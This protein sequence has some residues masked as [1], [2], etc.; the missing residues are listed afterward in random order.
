MALGNMQGDG[1]S[2]PTCFYCGRQGH[3]KKNCF[4]WQRDN[5]GGNRGGRGGRNGRGGGRSGLNA[6][7][8]GA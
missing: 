7:D 2:N 8:I 3:I 1:G 5:G 6:M 4:K